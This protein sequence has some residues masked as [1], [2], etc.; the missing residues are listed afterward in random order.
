[1]STRPIDTS[2]EHVL[3]DVNAD[4]LTDAESAAGKKR[5]RSLVLIALILLYIL[6]GSTYLGMYIALQSF[7]P[8]LMAGIR[9][10]LAG[11]IMFAFLCWRRAPLPTRKEWLG[12]IIVGIF[13]LVGGNAGVAF[14]EQWVPTGISA[15]A[16]GAVPLWVALFSGLFGRWPKRIEWFGLALGFGGLLLLN[17]GDGLSVNPLG[18]IVLLIA[19]L[20]WAFGSVLSQ[21]LTMPKGLM[22]SAAQ[23][24]CAGPALLLIGLGGGERIVHWPSAEAL[25]AM[26]FLIVGG[27]LV[28][29]TAYIYL[30]NHV[31]PALATSYAY[32]NPV[33]AV[34]LGVWLAGEQITW[35][36]VI[37]M[38]IILSGVVLVTMGHERK[39]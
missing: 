12:A 35:P 37:A 32:V 17:L 39:K 26:L 16:I 27:S 36:G 13:L 20:C 6:W 30:L 23:M 29:F 33:V 38:S 3:L 10:T 2:D 7:P 28:A 19:P 31:R 15:V 14:A 34:G 1:M 18:T 4:A 9:F 24:L 11:S 5:S 8:F 22:S 21:R 25:W